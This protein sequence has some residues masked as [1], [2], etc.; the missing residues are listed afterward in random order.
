MKIGI[1]KEIKKLEN[2]VGLTPSTAK[3]LVEDGNEVFVE[4]GAGEGSSFSD[5]AYEEA[6]VT[7]VSSAA[8]AWDNKMIIK[9]KEPLEE[10]YEFFQEYQI[11][12]T[13]LHLAPAVKLTDKLLEKKVTAV[14]YETMVQNGQ[15]PLLAPM[16]QVAGR[17]AAHIGS[18]FLEKTYGGKGILLGSVPG[19]ER[20][21]VV[22]IG[23]GT[24]G[25]QA[26]RVA[27][28]FGAKVTVLDLNP[29]RLNELDQIFDGEV[30][31][32]M[33]NAVNIA[34]SVKDADLVI[35]GVLIPGRTAPV[36]VTEEMVKSMD[37]G[38]VIIDIAIDQGGNVED[39]H[40][41]TLD[42]PVFERHG[43]LHYSVANVPGSVPRTATKAL[44]NVTTTFAKQI[45]SKGIKQA[46]LDNETVLTGINT[47]DGKMTNEPVAED[48][49]REYYN[50]KE[51]LQN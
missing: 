42:K 5:E 6:G 24:V 40:A 29:A 27:R 16:S 41:T 21:K 12:Y 28:G 18:Q 37:P 31:T 30:D 7:I 51:L 32:V 35:A 49:G 17:S 45:A 43:V 46:A 22:I 9:V 19:V 11:L 48:Q 34:N 23:G 13:F 26:A 1:P 38:S 44:A 15:L 50:P 4:T 20:G 2:R 8:E 36:L 25:E 3:L 33:S 47:Y 10:E 14:A 39:N